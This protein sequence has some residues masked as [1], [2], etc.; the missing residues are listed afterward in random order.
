MTSVSKLLGERRRRRRRRAGRKK[1]EKFFFFSS[2]FHQPIERKGKRDEFS[3]AGSDPE[4]KE[5]EEGADK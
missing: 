5:A 1:R 3:A 4:G 2:F